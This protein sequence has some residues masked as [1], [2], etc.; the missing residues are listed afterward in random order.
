MKFCKF[1]DAGE[2]P[3]MGFLLKSE[4]DGCVLYVVC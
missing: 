3:T 4:Y 1:E 2:L